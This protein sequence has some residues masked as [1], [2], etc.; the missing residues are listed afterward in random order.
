MARLTERQLIERLRE[1]FECSA[2]EVTLGIGD[3]AAVL[4]AGGEPYV[5]SVDASVQGVHFDLRWLSLSDVGYRS[6]Q[7]A[8]SDLAAMGAQPVAA[9]SALIL[10][11]GLSPEQIDELTLGQREASIE[12]SCP[13]AGGN[14]ARGGELSV[15]TTVFGRCQRPL[16]RSGARPGEQLWLV[17]EIGLAA[18]GLAHLRRART[19]VLAT[20]PERSAVERSVQAWRRPRALIARGIELGSCASATIDVSDGL[21]SDVRQLAAASGVRLIVNLRSLRRALDGSLL[22]ASRALR[23]SPLGFAIRGGE[24][25]A[26]LATGAPTRRPAWAKPIGW[27]SRGRGAMLLSQG[28]LFPLGGGFDHLSRA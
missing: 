21:A 27:V 9:L 18:A 24:D 17:G 22:Q 14:I 12:T 2:N 16:L 8:V 3:D 13:I 10:P 4:S 6:F 1:R 11:R 5:V 28:R 15:T 25:Y 26:L 19:P 23:R 20:L 7:A